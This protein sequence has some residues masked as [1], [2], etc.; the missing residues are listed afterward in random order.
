M[1]LLIQVVIT[2]MLVTA[3][4]F[5][6]HA[7]DFKYTYG[8]VAYEDINLTVGGTSRDG[9][10]FSLAGAYE[11]S[12]DIFVTASYAL[13]DLD[14]SI[15]ADI[16]GLGAGY[17]TSLRE[18]TDLVIHG[19]F[20]RVK[21]SAVSSFGIDTWSADVGVRHRLTDEFELGGKIGLVKYENRD[22]ET[23][24]GVRALYHFNESIAALLS[25]VFSDDGDTLS[26]G[27]RYHF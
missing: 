4:A 17:H 1:K 14:P 7:G 9:D 18:G 24:Y 27:A 15:D 12:G 21:L 23:E 19:D 20:G 10:G 8:Q 2:G 25:G 26:V 11:V 5:T 3:L 22:S 6:G 13:W 16:W